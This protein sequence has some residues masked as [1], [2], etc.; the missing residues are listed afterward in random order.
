MCVC[1]ALL[2]VLVTQAHTWL[3]QEKHFSN[4]ET[5]IN[6]HVLRTQFRVFNI[7]ETYSGKL[8]VDFTSEKKKKKKSPNPFVL[9]G[10]NKCL[11][12]HAHFTTYLKAN[13]NFDVK[14]ACFPSVLRSS[15]LTLCPLLSS[16]FQ[17]HT[18]PA[19]LPSPPSHTD[20]HEPLN[21]YLFL[22]VNA[23]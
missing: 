23:F 18:H 2:F 22:S 3:K 12:G 8:T 19:S 17:A 21:F 14:Q 1:L 9:L 5:K 20:S 4:S 11:S 7:F 10:T 6:I 13:I 15:S 16:S